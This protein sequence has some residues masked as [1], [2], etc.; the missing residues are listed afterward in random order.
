M[1]RWVEKVVV[2]ILGGV[3]MWERNEDSG[4]VVQ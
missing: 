2:R 4:R 1:G 3:G